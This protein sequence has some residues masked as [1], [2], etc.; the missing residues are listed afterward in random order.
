M[1]V[2]LLEHIAEFKYYA[3]HGWSETCGRNH[4]YQN[5][6]GR[7]T[8]R[9]R[10]SRETGI[11]IILTNKEKAVTTITNSHFFLIPFVAISG[12][13]IFHPGC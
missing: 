13:S 6:K 3:K 10:Q 4:W 8:N 12:K 2:C 11:Q 5:L 7:Q 9:L 1:E